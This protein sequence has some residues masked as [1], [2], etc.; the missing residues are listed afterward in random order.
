MESTQETITLHEVRYSIFLILLEY[1]YTDKCI[2]PLDNA[3][4]VLAAA[5]QFCISRLKILCENKLLGSL[6]I[7]N[8]AAIYFEAD[9]YDAVALK[10]KTLR[11]IIDHFETI[12]KTQCFED[13]ARRN[14]ELVFEILHNR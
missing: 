12:S 2:I 6:T 13:M 3:M 14:V 4:E 11:Y 5:D 1:L 7:E 9:A 8:A 10:S